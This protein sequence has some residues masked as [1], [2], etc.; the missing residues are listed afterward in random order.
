[1]GVNV[2]NMREKNAKSEEK[3]ERDTAWDRIKEIQQ[4]K[5][6][7]REQADTLSVLSSFLSLFALLLA[8]CLSDEQIKPTKSERS[9]LVRHKP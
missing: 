4:K 6:N 7:R 1:M 3:R 9:P 8:D 2:K 5:I